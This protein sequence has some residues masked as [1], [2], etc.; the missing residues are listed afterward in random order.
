MTSATCQYC[1]TP[2]LVGGDGTLRK[3]YVAHTGSVCAG[4]GTTPRADS[5]APRVRP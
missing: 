4:S 5:L 1:Q 2:Q 3:H